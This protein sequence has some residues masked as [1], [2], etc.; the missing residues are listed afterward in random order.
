MAPRGGGNGTARHEEECGRVVDDNTTPTTHVM[1]AVAMMTHYYCSL[2]ADVDVVSRLHAVGQLV[3]K[4]DADGRAQRRRR[5]GRRAAAA[6]ATRLV[7]QPNLLVAGEQL[8]VG[9]A[10]ELGAGAAAAAAWRIFGG[11]ELG[12]ATSKGRRECGAHGGA[13]QDLLYI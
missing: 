3:L 7:L 5:R 8:H 6:A 2:T 13:A 11:W 9:R 12:V 1:M 4:H 10:L